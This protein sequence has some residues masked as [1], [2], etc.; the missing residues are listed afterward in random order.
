MEWVISSEK[1]ASPSWQTCRIWIS[2]LLL[3]GLGAP[4][5]PQAIQRIYAASSGQTLRLSLAWMTFM[6]QRAWL[7]SGTPWKASPPGTPIARDHHG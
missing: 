3:I 6:P 4:L 5:Y 2:S 7:M 1:I